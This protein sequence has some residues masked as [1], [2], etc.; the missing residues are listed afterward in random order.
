[1]T[2]LASLTAPGLTHAAG[3]LYRVKL[4]ATGTNPTQLRAK[5]WAAGAPEPDA[6]ALSA[7][8]A[9]AALQSPGAV[10]LAAYAGSATSPLPARVLWDD[11]SIADG[12][13]PPAPPGYY[14]S[15]VGSDA[16]AGTAAAPWRTLQKAAD[17]V[18]AGATVIVRGGTHAGFVMRRSGTA[19][20]R[21][22]FQGYPGE[23]ATV[24]GDA[25]HAH[26]IELR[27]AR[28]VTLRG[29]VVRGAHERYSAGVNVHGGASDIVV[30]DC[31][32]RDNH[33]FGLRTYGATNVT[34]RRSTI[35]KNDSGVRMDYAATGNVVEDSDIFENTG[36]V[37]DDT[38]GGNDTGANALQFFKTTGAVAVRRNRMYGNRAPS[39]DYGY[40]GGAVEI[41]A[42]SDLTIS[43]N[44]IWNNQNV[45]ETGTESG[46]ECANN[47]FLRNV[48]W[49][50]NDKSLVAPRG[51]L[52]NGLLLRCARNMLVAN[53][54]FEDLDYWV[55]D[56][57]VGDSKYA[58]SI[59]GLTIR[60]NVGRQKGHAVYAI[61][62]PLPASVVIDHNLSWN[63][64]GTIAKVAG[65]GTT[66]SLATFQSWT[67]F[68]LH[69]VAADPGFVDP[70]RND[71]RLI[72]TSPAID[73][74]AR[75]AGVTDG[76]LGPAPDMGR[77]EIR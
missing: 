65:R 52:V 29:L 48:A 63:G 75:L 61:S 33:S 69:G 53:N 19:S 38:T 22:V 70:A 13:E 46:I 20:G 47:R 67:G 7:T 12:V 49:G 71:Y 56:V 44:L 18:P 21:I 11:L 30:E 4:A 1:M 72:T 57:A 35:T 55:Y 5:I 60:N 36:M 45:V 68:D 41:Y 3:S 37:V 15:T 50:G 64:G 27:G 17:T 66:S 40:D 24:T 73:R 54:T 16:A 74:G 10:G 25:A 76:F 42:S 43:E 59:E 58:G 34:V 77:W 32:L 6:W 28:F 2:T 23:T 26:A 51:P 31:T 14:V 9:A 8:D 39:H 62:A